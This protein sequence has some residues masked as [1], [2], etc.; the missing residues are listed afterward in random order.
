MKV[1][2]TGAN[3]FLG[4]HIVRILLKEGHTVFSLVRPHSDLR[5]LPNKHPNHHIIDTNY[6]TDGKVEQLLQDATLDALVHNAAKAADWGNFN[7]F[8]QT[9]VELCALIH[10]LAAKYKLPRIVHISSNAVLGE[11]DCPQKKAENAPYKA[12]LPYFLEN[13]IPSAM[14]FYRITK[15]EGEQVAIKIAQEQ[16]NNLIVLRPVWIFGPR[17]FHAGPFEY[18]EAVINGVFAMPGCNTNLYHTVYVE[19]VAHAVHLAIQKKCNGIH[20][21]NIGP[22]QIPTLAEFHSLLCLQL[23]KKKPLGLPYFLLFLPVLLLEIAYLIFRSNKAPL[24]TRARLYLFYANN[25]Y[26]VQKAKKELGFE[27]QYDLKRAIRKTVKWWKIN[28]FL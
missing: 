11:E 15:A 17:E 27:N 18:C 5:F 19:D 28:H 23:G 20:I 21:Y 2:V 25:V 12:R 14:N 6:F 7:D 4:S 1:A 13:I 10:K 3:G 22:S 16:N 24:L 26:E 8:Y 9:N